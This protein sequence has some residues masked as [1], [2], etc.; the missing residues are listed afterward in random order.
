MELFFNITGNVKAS[1][2][3]LT[4][5]AQAFSML[6]EVGTKKAVISFFESVACMVCAV[7]EYNLQL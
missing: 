6:E 1:V 3:D 2:H 4:V 7:K 5:S